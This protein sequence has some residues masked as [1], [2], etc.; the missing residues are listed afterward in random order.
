[1]FIALAVYAVVA[2][3]ALLAVGA[4]ELA[5]TPA[6][7]SVVV[8]AS[9]WSWAEPI[10]K[11]G[12]AAAALG[13][14]LSLLAGVSRTTFAMAAEHDLPH[15]LAAVDERRR[16]PH[17]AEIAIGGAVAA[18]VLVVDLRGAI[19]FSSFA[20]LAYYAIANVSRLD[21]AADTRDDGRGRSR[22]PDWSGA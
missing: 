4:R 6:P 2:I 14:L 18:T 7:L 16:V 17:R 1:M 11:I 5:S 10:V 20:V 19:G 22:W 3:A 12:A 9:P 13:V 15:W 21:V 8:E